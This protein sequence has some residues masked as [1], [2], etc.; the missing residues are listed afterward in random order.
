MCWVRPPTPFFSA[1]A[2]NGP[3]FVRIR[4]NQPAKGPNK[5]LL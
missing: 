4:I 5:R 1:G 2:S 3:S